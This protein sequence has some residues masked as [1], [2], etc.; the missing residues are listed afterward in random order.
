M[1]VIG[2]DL[3]TTYS[4]SAIVRGPSPEILENREGERLTP[5]VV[6]FENGTPLVGVEAKRLA[7]VLPD[8]CVEFVKRKMGEPEAAY[9]DADGKEYRA[10]EVSAL[11]LKRLAADASMQLGE[12]VRDV[13]VTVPAYFDDARRTATK[14]AGEIAGLNV[15]GLINEPTAA[16][17]AYGLNKQQSGVFLVYDL[18]GG[19]FDVTIMRVTGTEFDIMATGG[20]RNLGGFD[21]D[22][23]LMGHVAT[24]IRE[25]GGPEVRESDKG[26]AELRG[27]CEQAKRRLTS[28]PQTIVRVSA[29]GASFQVPVT[30]AEFEELTAS[31][32]SRTEVTVEEVMEKAGVDWDKIDRILLVGGSTRMPMVS[33]MV[34]RM[35]GRVPDIGINPDEAVALGAAVYADTLGAA[36]S[37]AIARIPVAVSD[38]TSQSLGTIALNERN[39]AQ[40]SIII[41]A[42]S[43]IPVKREKSFYTVQPGQRVVDFELTEGD[44][45][46]LRYVTVLKST[47]LMLPPGLPDEAEIRV[48][49]AY[50]IDGVVHAEVF[51]GATGQSLGAVELQRDNNLGAHAV[52]QMRNAMRDL[53]IL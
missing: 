47:E 34:Q 53:E 2:I 25:Q 33:T 6:V 17:I 4:A 20:D 23:L 37:G 43:K 48:V 10:E 32:L 35:S 12:E 45:E 46:D 8:D 29:E 24:R 13:V 36:A 28:M 15:L 16:G 14:D 41:P 49:M 51:L 18:G 50:D 52:E 42:N 21:F 1:A 3:G 9:V 44:D 30:R 38:V 39:I 5:S 27:Q 40:N 22:N 7:A 31:L 19:T 26:E 11:V